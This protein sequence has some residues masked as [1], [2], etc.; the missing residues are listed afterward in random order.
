MIGE[1]IR[2]IGPGWSPDPA[3]REREIAAQERLVSAMCDIL[4]ELPKWELEAACDREIQ[5]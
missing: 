5:P 4:E 2:T 1:T 3:E